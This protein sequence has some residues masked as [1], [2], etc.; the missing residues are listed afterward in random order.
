MEQQYRT[1]L[2]G[3]EI[4]DIKTPRL[5]QFNFPPPIFRLRGKL[6]FEG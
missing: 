6:V 5:I 4:L 2:P 1:R 3:W